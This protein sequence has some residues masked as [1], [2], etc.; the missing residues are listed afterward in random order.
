[1][2][3]SACDARLAVITRDLATAWAQTAQGWRDEKR[4]EFA[5]RYLAELFSDVG[6]AKT[7]IGELDQIISKAKKDCE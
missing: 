5:K 7:I 4:D 2:S 6:S 3:L 1:M